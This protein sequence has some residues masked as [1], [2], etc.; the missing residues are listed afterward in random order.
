MSSSTRDGTFAEQR[1]FVR[2]GESGQEATHREV[3]LLGE[4]FGRRHERALVAALHGGEQR[5]ERDDGLPRTDLPLQE[6]VH[7]RVGREIARDLVDRPLLVVRQRER[8]L[9][10]EQGHQ[11]TVD[12]VR[13]AALLAFERALARHQPD[14]HP[15]ELVELEP[16]RGDPEVVHRLGSVDPPE[17]R[18]TV[19]EVGAPADLALDGV[20]EAAPACALE[21]GAH[22]A[23]ELPAVH[24]GLAR[25]RVH[26][27]ELAGLVA[28]LTEHVDDRV[29]HLALAPEQ[30]DLP[31]E[32]RLR[33]LGELLLAERL[34]E[35]HDVEQPGPVVDVRLDHRAAAVA[36]RPC[37]DAPHLGVDRDLDAELDLG[38]LGSQRP[39][40]VAARVVREQVQDGVDLHRVQPGRELGPDVT[41]LR[42]RL[43]GEVTQRE[44]GRLRV[45][46]RRR[47]GPATRRR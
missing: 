31:E 7:R 40:V 45:P 16:V 13:D 9:P 6:A 11:R 29:R 25:R 35:E 19:D 34:V 38:D 26:G 2:H 18:R 10:V 30:L 17:R 44:T 4:D 1:C 39:V 23:G 3:V 27:D 5:G 24:V 42:H 22:D 21:R 33:S 28:E 15:E 12:A 20:R 43:R 37:A 32:R 14:L 47:H 46:E 41:Q 36:H 8:Q